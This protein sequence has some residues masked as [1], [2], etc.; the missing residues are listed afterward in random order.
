[1][2]GKYDGRAKFGRPM[3]WSLEGGRVG[4]VKPGED[5]GSLR[6]YRVSQW[7]EIPG[8]REIRRETYSA[9]V[10]T[11]IPG[12]PVPPTPTGWRATG[13]WYRNT[14]WERVLLDYQKD[15]DPKTEHDVKIATLD[16]DPELA[17]GDIALSLVCIDNLPVAYLSPY[18][19]VVP[20]GVDTYGVAIWDRTKQ[21]WVDGIADQVAEQTDDGSQ[22]FITNRAVLRSI[23]NTLWRAAAGLPEGQAFA[24]GMWPS[25]QVDTRLTASFDP[26]GL[27]DALEHVGCH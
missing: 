25:G 4:A 26:K 15:V 22:L 5:I 3:S 11:P 1:M 21:E 6:V 2:V 10:P 14:D 20:E 27:E 9:L 13:H 18:S 24:A 16:A 7:A 19:L 8:A 17:Q 12:S 23:I